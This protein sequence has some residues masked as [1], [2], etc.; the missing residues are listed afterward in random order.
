MLS[1]C[2][3]THR[4][5][6]LHVYIYILSRK[7]CLFTT[8]LIFFALLHSGRVK[9]TKNSTRYKWP[10]WVCVCVCI[11]L[12]VCVGVGVCDCVCSG[13]CACVRASMLLLLLLLLEREG[14]AAAVAVVVAVAAIVAW[15]FDKLHRF[16]EAAHHRAMIMMLSCCRRRCQSHNVYLFSNKNIHIK[17][18]YV[19]I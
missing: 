1:V 8:N 5:K 13:F 3:R 6:Y 10:M 14:V 9:G 17:Y 7:I 19:C 15:P 2:T 12:C 16:A 18:V 11:C 4:C